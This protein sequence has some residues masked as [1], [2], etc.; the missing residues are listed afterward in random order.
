[1]PPSNRFPTSPT[2]TIRIAMAALWL[3]TVSASTALAQTVRDDFWMPDGSAQAI[4]VSNG[5]VYF[6]GDFAH[7]GPPTGGFATLDATTGGVIPP[8][9]MVAPT[10][11]SQFGSY[12][13]YAIAPDGNGGCYVGGDFARWQGQPRG[14][15]VH[16]DASG[17][18]L[19]F[20]PGTDRAVRALAFDA[21]SNTLY[22]GGGFTTIG[23]QSRSHLAAVNGT[24]GVPTTWNPQPVDVS[25]PIST[26]VST[27]QLYGGAVYVGGDFTS[28]GGQNRSNLAAIDA[29]GAATAWNPGADGFVN[30]IV[31]YSSPT[32]LFATV[33]YVGGGFTTLAGQPRSHVG[34]V[35][36][37]GAAT[38]WNPGVNQPVYVVA[39]AGGGIHTPPTIYLGGGFETVG[40][41]PRMFLASVDPS[42][43]VTS[44]D[45]HADEPVYAISGSSPLYVGGG[46]STV[47]GQAR[48]GVAALDGTG[49]ATAWNPGAAGTVNALVATGS[50]VLAGGS[51][52]TAG[53]VPRNHL[54]AIDETTG[55]PTSWDPNADGVVKALTVAG[56]LIYAGG[57][58]TTVHGQSHPYV[59]QLGTDGNP[60]SW[61]P[62]P[63]GDVEALASRTLTSQHHLIYMGGAFTTVSGQP[64]NRLAAMGDQLIDGLDSW[65]PN[66]EGGDVRAL[67]VHGSAIGIAG[68]FTSLGGS[69]LYGGCAT[70]DLTGAPR[71]RASPVGGVYAIAAADTY[72]VAGGTFT[73]MAGRRRDGLAF[74]DQ[75]LADTIW[76]PYLDY[77]GEV[78]A[79]AAQGSIVYIAGSFGAIAD[80][81][82][83]GLAAF[84]FGSGQLT[85]WG[86]NTEAS[87]GSA[88]ALDGGFAFVG[89]GYGLATA[90]HAGLVALFTG[91]TGVVASD[92]SPTPLDLRVHGNPFRDRLSLG[93]RLAAPAETDVRVCDIAG[94]SVRRLEHGAWTAGAHELV[95]DGRDDAGR[96]APAGMYFVRVTADGATRSAKVLRLE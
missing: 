91:T 6:G 14:D 86:T 90:E 16:L 5:I 77:Q 68:F 73:M 64:R 59:V 88:L 17:A 87:Y 74:L 94:R 9:A 76:D 7:V 58:F 83:N 4:A 27:L 40:G 71:L 61:N 36:V 22:V 54:A 32:L 62:N 49:A 63:N 43:N 11:D 12:A 10:P 35:D 72:W 15:L 18:L 57:S 52:T 41:Q 3:A 95:W 48:R 37:N 24:T 93:L 65:N 13:V 2:T 20:N 19:P 33:I 38:S 21:S 53:G 60:G 85:D 42:G 25:S 96:A 39:L 78:D 69:T 29:S 92:A 23:G 50:T 56:G 66:A 8:Y 67:T 34:A 70:V 26:A 81:P 45:P 44:W 55:Q 30:S 28:I 1:M 82:R 31:V 80:Y 47:G 46:F 84:D 51:F 75:Y 79:L 89:G